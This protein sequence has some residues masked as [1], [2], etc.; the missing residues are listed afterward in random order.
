MTNYVGHRCNPVIKSVQSYQILQKKLQFG[1]T[2]KITG[3]ECHNLETRDT[4]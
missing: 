1:E 3:Y 4:I 2:V